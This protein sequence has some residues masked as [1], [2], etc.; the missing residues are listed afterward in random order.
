MKKAAFSV[1]IITV[2]SKLVG[3]A[4]EMVLSYV[5][6]ASAL[7]DAYLISQTVPTVIFSFVSAGI[8]TGFIPMYSRI[9]AEYGKGEADRYTSNL[10]NALLL[11]ASIIVAIVFLVAKPV[12]KAFALGFSGETLEMAVRLTR[13][14]VF[15]VYFTGLTNIFSG[16]LRLH[17]DFIIPALIGFPMN[18]VIIG[19]LFLS[20]KTSIYVL[21]AGSVVATSSQVLLCIPSMQ[22]AGYRHSLSLNLRNDHLKAMMLLAL[23]VIVGTAVNDINVLVDR[24]MA[25]RIAVGAIS[26]LNY[27][28]RLNGFVQGLFVVS[29]TTVL[30]PMIA[31]MAAEGK[32][33]SLKAYLAEAMTMVNLLVVPST[34]GA[35]IFSHE[36][37]TLLFGR[38]AFRPEAIDMTGV[39]LFYYSISM[40]AFGMRDVLTRVFYSLHD[41][42]TPMINSAVAVVVNIA[43][44]IILSRFL[45]IGGLALA[46]SISGILSA[47]LM[48]IKL[49]KKIGPFGLKETTKSFAKI[50]GA[51]TLMAIIAQRSFVLF[52]RFL[53]QNAALIAAIGVGALTYGVLIL[54]MRV[55]EVDRTVKIVRHRVQ[56]RFMKKEEPEG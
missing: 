4:R 48:F 43:L 40:I 52:Q 25:S 55:P 47:V 35:M 17:G 31:K 26:A 49:R 16:Y 6:G 18:L 36:V 29:V 54:S 8:A 27:A 2:L 30:Y 11:V 10:S 5:Y 37:V 9:L 28:R 41:T 12:V 14:S 53:T 7:T 42:R 33:R 34:V 21:A 50:V 46:T 39:A 32:L 24:T 15:G 1:M 51:S 22:K 44:N 19:S 13:I 23:P 56:R 3:F 20:S 38:G 45:G